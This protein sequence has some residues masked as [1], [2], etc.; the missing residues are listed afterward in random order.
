MPLQ[1]LDETLTDHAGI[2][3][4]PWLAEIL[5][6]S[7]RIAQEHWGIQAIP[8]VELT[9]LPQAREHSTGSNRAVDI[10]TILAT[11]TGA[12]PDRAGPDR[13]R[14]DR[15]G[16]DQLVRDAVRRVKQVMEADEVI[17]ADGTSTG[18]RRLHRKQTARTGGRA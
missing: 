3:E 18:R 5:S 1:Q 2:A 7:C 15:A 12:G 11:L 17:V 16:P 8:G 14:P 13:A 4:L 6:Q 10:T 9:H